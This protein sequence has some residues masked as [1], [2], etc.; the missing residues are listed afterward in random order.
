MSDDA[1]RYTELTSVSHTWDAHMCSE[2]LR[3]NGVDAH[4]L[5]DQ[6][7]SMEPYLAQMIPVRIMVPTDQVDLA[8]KLLQELADAPAESVPELQPE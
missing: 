1:P 7:N 3:S 8:N 6:H 5:N 2:F 4:L